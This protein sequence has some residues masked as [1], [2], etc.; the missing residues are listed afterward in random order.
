MFSWF[1]YIFPC[2]GLLLLQI[3]WYNKGKT[4]MKKI[5]AGNRGIPVIGETIQFMA[6][7]NSNKGFYDFIKIR[8]LK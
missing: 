1:W 6:T 7:I 5:P 3:L 2:L 4:P 8:R